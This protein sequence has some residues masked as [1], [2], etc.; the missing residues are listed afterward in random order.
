L[1]KAVLPRNTV[2][3][4]PVEFNAS[5]KAFEKP[6]SFKLAQTGTFGYHSHADVRHDNR[7][8][9]ERVS[10]KALLGTE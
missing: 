1:Q 9:A 10:C 2:S 7:K 6:Q 5:Q 3:D 4:N 8:N